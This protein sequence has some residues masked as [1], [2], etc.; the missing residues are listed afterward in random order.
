VSL[1]ANFGRRDSNDSPPKSILKVRPSDNESVISEDSIAGK[2][3]KV[4]KDSIALFMDQNGSVEMQE[5]R[6]EHALRHWKPLSKNHLKHV[7]F[8]CVL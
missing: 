8:Y 2:K 7:R 1:P 4:R 3:F 5:L 6:K